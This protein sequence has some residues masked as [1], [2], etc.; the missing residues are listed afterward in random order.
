MFDS[1]TMEYVCPVCGVVV[2]YEM[3]PSFTHS[4]HVER[5]STKR[6]LDDDV[7]ELAEEIFSED[8]LKELRRLR[9]NRYEYLLQVLDAVIRKNDYSIDWSVLRKAMEVAKSCGVKV[10]ISEIRS[11]QVLSAI[12]SV[13]STYCPD[14]SAEDVYLFATKHKD[15]WSGR[16]PE[17]VALVFTYLYMKYKLRRDVNIPL[18]PNTRKLIKIFEKLLS[19]RGEL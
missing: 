14:V 16:K 2:G 7:I 18:R 9:K 10:N 11:E 3:I 4:T 12:T 6:R 17:T 19:E 1:A 13:V 15:L 5:F 8:V